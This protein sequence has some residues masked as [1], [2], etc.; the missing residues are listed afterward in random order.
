MPS[1]GNA[2][3]SD[4]SDKFSELSSLM[5]CRF[6]KPRNISPSNWNSYVLCATHKATRWIKSGLNIY[7]YEIVADVAAFLTNKGYDK[8]IFNLDYIDEDTIEE[9]EDVMNNNTTNNANSFVKN[10]SS[11]TTNHYDSDDSDSDSDSESDSC[12]SEDDC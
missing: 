6:D 2:R 8:I 7:S 5:R 1:K 9:M 3:K 12:D 10:T 11:C 4:Y